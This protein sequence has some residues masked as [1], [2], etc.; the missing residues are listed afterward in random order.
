MKIKQFSIGE[1][2]KATGC[3]IETMRY[4]EKIGLLQPAERTSGNQR[5]YGDPHY[6]RLLFIL[7]ARDLG[8]SIDS[9][10]QLIALSKHPDEPCGEADNIARQQLVETRA[11]IERLKML[12]KELERMT[13]NC[14]G[15]K[16]H[17]CQ[18]IE[19]LADCGACYQAHHQL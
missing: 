11:R 15:H 3:N 6:K 4:Y 2:S 14:G 12:E 9:I 1:L 19:S 18:V 7:H 17:D 10:R 8:F 16:V 5:R 13:E